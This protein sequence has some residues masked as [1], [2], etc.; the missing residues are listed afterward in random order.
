[1]RQERLQTVYTNRGRGRE[2]GR[3]RTKER[4]RETD[5]RREREKFGPPLPLGSCVDASITAEPKQ[6]QT[7]PSPGQRNGPVGGRGCCPRRHRQSRPHSFKPRTPALQ[8]Q[9]QIQPMGTSQSS[10]RKDYMCFNTVAMGTT[11]REIL[12]FFLFVF[13]CK[14]CI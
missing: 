6:G 7:A 12:L 11:T 5:R 3:E 13:L 2:G 4:E 14:T 8:H 1:M 9:G 10:S